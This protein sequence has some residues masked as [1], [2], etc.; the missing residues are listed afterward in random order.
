MSVGGLFVGL[1]TL[2][3][4][5]LVDRLPGPNEKTV[6]QRTWLAAGGPARGGWWVRG[7]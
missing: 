1:A 2:D 6:A 4:V 7:G 3:V 5:Q